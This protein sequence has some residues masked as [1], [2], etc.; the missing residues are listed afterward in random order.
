MVEVAQ[1]SNSSLGTAMETK[2]RPIH[3]GGPANPPQQ[4]TTGLAY[5]EH[6]LAELQTDIGACLLGNQRW[7]K[8]LVLAILMAATQTT[9]RHGELS[10]LQHVPLGN[11]ALKVRNLWKPQSRHSKWRQ[12]KLSHQELKVSDNL[13]LQG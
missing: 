8:C 12:W 11:N 3:T 5:L 10:D 6:I 2:I 7:S 1:K 9:G 4:S 13:N